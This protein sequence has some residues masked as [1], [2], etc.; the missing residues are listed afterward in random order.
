MPIGRPSVT[1]A[2]ARC[3]PAEADDD[4][5]AEIIHAEDAEDAPVA[6]LEPSSGSL[7]TAAD[8]ENQNPANA[9]EA[10]AREEVVSGSAGA[11]RQRGARAT[12]EKRWRRFFFSEGGV[13]PHRTERAAG[14]GA[15]SRRRP[16]VS[17]RGKKKALAFPVETPPP[18]DA[19]PVCDLYE[20][21]APSRWRDARKRGAPRRAKRASLPRTP[22]GGGKQSAPSRTRARPADAL[23]RAYPG[24]RASTSGFS[25]I[26]GD[27]AVGDRGE[28]RFLIAVPDRPQT[29][30]MRYTGSHDAFR[31]ELEPAPVVPEKE[32]VAAREAVLRRN[33][34]ARRRTEPSAVQLCL[35]GSA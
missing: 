13:A 11:S 31:G 3:E 32:R 29:G 26:A 34:E 15:A 33:R 18:R 9:R 10:G 25:R 5:T 35:R 23:A 24:A 6:A 30:M 12:K 8:R 21:L 14:F 19:P 17:R 7:A 4:P 20:H 28:P 2:E 27:A 22:S 1:A 16:T